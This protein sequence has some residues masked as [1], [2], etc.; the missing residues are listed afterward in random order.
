MKSKDSTMRGKHLTWKEKMRRLD[1]QSSLIQIG[2]GKWK[3]KRGRREERGS[4]PPPPWAVPLRV[5]LE[6]GERAAL[7]FRERERERLDIIS[8]PNIIMILIFNY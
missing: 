5:I 2:Q 7:R 8:N 1:S 6:E 3:R 4:P